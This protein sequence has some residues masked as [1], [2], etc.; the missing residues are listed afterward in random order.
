MVVHRVA[1]VLLA[2]W[3]AVE[4]WRALRTPGPHVQRVRTA[5][6][7]LAERLDLPALDDRRAGQ[8]VRAHGAAMVLGAGALALG[9]APR[10]AALVLADLSLPLTVAAALDGPDRDRLV[11]TASMTGGALLAA[12]DR[13]GKPSMAWRVA[14][15]R[16][17]R[18]HDAR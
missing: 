13:E 4:G 8:L 18:V 15:A 11:T 16:E 14:Q 2:G 6:H 9:P 3:F 1:R 17:R 5:Y 7:R 12:L 10:T